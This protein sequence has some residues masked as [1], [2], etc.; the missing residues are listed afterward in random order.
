VNT[1]EVTVVDYVDTDDEVIIP[2]HVTDNG[3]VIY[4]V[5]KIGDLAFYE[6][7]LTSITIPPS[8][9][10]IGEGA[11]LYNELES[12]TF[13]ASVTSIG[14][15]AFIG[16]NDLTEV[17][18]LSENPAFLPN[19]IFN[20]K[21]AIL[22][23][24]PTGTAQNY[25][26][27]NWSGFGLVIENSTLNITEVDLSNPLSVITNANTLTIVSDDI[28]IKKVEI[29]AITGAKVAFNT[30]SNQITINHL[31]TGVY[32]AKIYTNKSIVTKKFIK[33]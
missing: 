15:N 17:T 7:G 18:S 25:T 10:A 27:Q 6:N 28:T 31:N 14:E 29:Y 9:T 30:S 16:N 24:I 23:N 33:Q 8:I 4:L 32:I 13:P 22:L 20:N 2:E 11:F 5:N 21:S 26:N 19:V 1:N 12:F 3:G